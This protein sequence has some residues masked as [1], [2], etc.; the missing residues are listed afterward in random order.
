MTARVVVWDAAMEPIGSAV[1]SVGVFDGVHLGHQTLLARAAA[2]GAARG[3][4]SVAVTFD[5]DPDQVVSPDSAAP[6]LLTLDD[7]L[8]FIAATGVDA[9]LVIPFTHEL[10]EMCPEEFLESVL[11]HGVTPLAVHVGADFRFGCRAEG[12]VATMQRIGVEHGF[13]VC[14]HDLVLVGGLP[15]TSSRIRALVAAG[16][17][18]AAAELLGRATRAVGRVHRGRGEGAS[19][20]FPT[21]NVVPAEFAALPADGVYAGRAILPDGRE[22]AAAISVGTPP[23]FPA[24]RDHLE[25]HLIGF[26]G[27]LYGQPLTLVFFARLR[28]QEAYVS[29]DALKTAIA[30]DVAKSLQIAGFAVDGPGEELDP[31]EA[32]FHDHLA[33]GSPVVTDPETL[34]AAEQ[35]ASHRAPVHFDD[36]ATGEWTPVVGPVEFYGSLGAGAKAFM[37]TAP[38]EAAGIPFA[39]DPYPPAERPLGLPGAGSYDQPFTLRVPVGSF[40][41]AHFLTQQALANEAA[42]RDSDFDAYIDDP[43]LLEAAEQA[44]RAVDRQ[45][46]EL[47]PEPLDGWKTIVRD[48]GY[49][50]K[51]LGAIEY[52]LSAAGI[53]AE[54]KPFS[55]TEAPLLKLFG[56][57]ETKFSLRVP[58]EDADAAREVMGEVDAR[59]DRG[60]DA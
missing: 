49:D 9:I 32:P 3:V 4:E 23:T 25:A 14:P 19:L 34:E 52:A 54:W 31:N 12:D 37:V 38:L 47:S 24:A 41:E 36:I 15:V 7:K 8:A 46:R 13:E 45:P 5:R 16:D 1:V 48:M 35:A 11:L 33:D 55:P 44:V 42:V 59:A 56:L 2:D 51:R 43:A 28:S 21:A 50:K 10:A 17:V 18:P 22:W 6:Q 58:Q 30:V 29:L 40:E 26:D 60:D 20:G 27:D 39:W 53:P 57:R